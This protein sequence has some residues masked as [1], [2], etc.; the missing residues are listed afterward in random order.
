MGPDQLETQKSEDFVATL[1][2]AGVIDEPWMSQL[3]ETLRS[4]PTD[5]LEGVDRLAEGI[6]PVAATVTEAVQALIRSGTG[7][8]RTND[9]RG[10]LDTSFVDDLRWIV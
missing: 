5:Q 10:R 3:L 6:W 2:A 9:D 1:F 7:S 8:G 4:L